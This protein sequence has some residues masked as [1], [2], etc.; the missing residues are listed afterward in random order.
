MN[1]DR[2]KRIGN[3]IAEL[4]ESLQKLESVT[5]DEQDVYDN[6]PE[7][8]QGSQRYEDMETA[9]DHLEEAKS[10]LEEA[11]SSLEVVN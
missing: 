4:N 10:S 8:L 5:G 6:M 7:N 3:I 1:K 2:R 9:I 11:I